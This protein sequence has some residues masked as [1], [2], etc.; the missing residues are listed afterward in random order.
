MN[1]ILIVGGVAGGASAAARLRRLDEFAEIIMF[2]KGEYISFANCGLPYYIGGDIKEKSSL[3]LQT[4]ESFRSRF[5]VDV[6]VNNQVMSIDKDAKQIKVLNVKT[7]EE[8]LESYDKLILSPGAEPV[9][10]NLPGINEPGVFTLRNIP[11]TYK[12]K[13]YITKEAVKTAVVVGGGY[14][15]M[16]MAENLQH[17]GL[18]VTVVEAA[19]HV[20]APLD[21]DMAC[22]VHNHIRQKGVN[23]I[24]NE[25]VKSIRS[26]NNQLAVVLENQ[27][28]LSDVV[29]MSVGVRPESKL[30]KDAGLN[31]NP[32]GSIIVDEF[33]HTSDDNIYAVGDAIEVTDYVVG[34]KTYIPLAGP[35]NKQ[36]RIA[37]DNICGLNRSYRGTQGT[38][39]LKCFDLTVGTTG[40]NET[41]AKMAGLNYE[42]S[43]TYSASHASYYPGAVNMSIKIIF[44]K[45]DGRLLGA[46]V[47]GYEGTDKRTDVLATAIR[48][49]MTIYDLAELELSYAPPFS[50]AKDPVNMAGFTAE[51]ILTGQTKIFHWDQVDSLPRDGSVTLIDIR[52]PIEYQN[53]TIEGFINIP[54][55]NLRENLHKLD[56]S[57]PVY[58]VCQIGLRGHVACR[59]LSQHGYECYNLSGGYRLYNTINRK[60]AIKETI[61][62]DTQR[63]VSAASVPQKT[64][65]VDACGLQCPG[66]IMKLSKAMNEAQTDD[67]ILIKSTDPAFNGDV[68]AWCKRT[69]NT[70]CSV[71]SEKGIS[72]ILV[73][74][75]GEQVDSFEGSNGKNII[76]FSG[77]LDKAIASFIIANAAASMGRK[78]SMF[79]T[80]WGLNILRRPEKVSVKKNLISKMFGF[81]M[82]RGSKKLKLSK[83][84]MA[85]IGAKMIRGIMKNKNI[86]SLE[87]LIQASMENGVELVACTMSMDVMG[88]KM[89]EL[90]D[91]VKLGGAAA[92]IAHAEES[93]MSLFI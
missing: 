57:K 40:I 9:R 22:D 21:F 39:I 2:E 62:V 52:T 55:D 25:A 16:E 1:K 89:E 91:G 84:N 65:E 8:Y 45:E 29:I 10:P 13:D 20:I 60:T 72:E 78:V 49:N 53:G 33:M 47:V 93:D 11:D 3:T 51:N 43:Y 41:R 66:P 15:G 24:L 67:V 34:D 71:K 5:N 44:N 42:K 86:D 80:F 85:G 73:K 27:E 70:L 76:V 82:P 31:I 30:A 74:K 35:A 28:I 7:G 48:A 26:V 32:K 58:V 61:N 37:A 77:D 63:F 64:I 18:K 75:G 12:I 81:M 38:G 6:R 56:K 90:I 83:M 92:M 46:Q 69:G 50:S 4:P 54:V 79:F 36:G 23:L 59:I 88:I 87:S 19:N 17:A 68:E 14:I